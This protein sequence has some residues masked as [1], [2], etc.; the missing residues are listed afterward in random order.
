MIEQVRLDLTRGLKKAENRSQRPDAT[1]GVAL[2][3]SDAR[4]ELELS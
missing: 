1:T 4:Q 2:A 3:G